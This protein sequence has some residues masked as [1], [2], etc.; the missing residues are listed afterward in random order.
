M[1]EG[2]INEEPRA[3]LRFQLAPTSV[4]TGGCCVRA[5]MAESRQMLTGHDSSF[6]EKCDYN[7]ITAMSSQNALARTC[8]NAAHAIAKTKSN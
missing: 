2:P 4:C 6:Q 5:Q 7:L 3:Y 1:P 8:I